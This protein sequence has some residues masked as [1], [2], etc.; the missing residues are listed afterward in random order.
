MH[1]LRSAIDLPGLPT[2]LHTLRGV[3]YQLKEPDAHAA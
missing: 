2:L 3:G 1:T